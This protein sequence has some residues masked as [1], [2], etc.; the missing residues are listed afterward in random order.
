MSDCICMQNIPYGSTDMSILLSA[1]GRT[2]I[3]V[4]VQ[5]QGSCNI[6]LNL[7]VE[8]KRQIDIINIDTKMGFPVT[9]EP[10]NYE[11]LIL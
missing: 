5:T 7:I 3:V 1:N 6:S 11:K 8:E 10:E 2:R 9:T 4:I